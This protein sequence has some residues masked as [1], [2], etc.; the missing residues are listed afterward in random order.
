MALKIIIRP[1]A[2]EDL[3][4]AICWYNKKKEILGEE[5]L[6]EF[7]ETLKIV[8]LHPLVF[9]KRYKQARAFGLKRFPYKIYYLVD[10]YALHVLAVIHQKRNPKVWKRRI[11]RS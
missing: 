8:S 7:V 1:L 6:L 9:R 2:E 10:D 3:D 11:R 4:D 5:F